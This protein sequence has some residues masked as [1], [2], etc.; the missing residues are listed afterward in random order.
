MSLFYTARIYLARSQT[1][2][3]SI[4]I[5]VQPPEHVVHDCTIHVATNIT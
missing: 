2:F 1:G 5:Y 4:Y 3:L